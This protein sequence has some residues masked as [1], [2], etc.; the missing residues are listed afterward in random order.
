[1]LG[2]EAAG[3][4]A[5]FERL[6]HALEQF[7]PPFRV[8]EH[9]DEAAAENAVLEGNAPQRAAGEHLGSEAVRWRGD[10]DDIRTWTFAGFPEHEFMRS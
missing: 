7:L 9:T 6:G 4:K 1:M 10:F 2:K 5:A 3:F 8:C